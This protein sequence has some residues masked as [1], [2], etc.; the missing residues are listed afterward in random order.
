MIFSVDPASGIAGHAGIEVHIGRQVGVAAAPDR[1][2]DPAHSRERTLHDDDVAGWRAQDV[3]DRRA[4]KVPARTAPAEHEDVGSLAPHEL[5]DRVPAASRHGHVRTRIR[6]FADQL[7]ELAA[8]ALGL[9]L[10]RRERLA[11]GDLDDRHEDQLA[12]RRE[13]RAEIDQRALALGIVDH[14]DA[15]HRASFVALGSACFASSPR[16]VAPLR[17]IRSSRTLTSRLPR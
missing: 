12:F 14:D 17:W 5:D 2:E 4:E 3:L 10:R 13:A 15:F 9:R 6:A 8:S 7:T 16:R 11:L 1:D